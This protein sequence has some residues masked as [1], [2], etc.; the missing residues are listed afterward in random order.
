MED[1]AGEQESDCR[2]RDET[3]LYDTPYKTTGTLLRIC[4]DRV[5]ATLLSQA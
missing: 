2:F 3:L 5:G 1:G 4:N